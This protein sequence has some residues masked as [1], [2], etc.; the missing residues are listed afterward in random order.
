M[1]QYVKGKFKSKGKT[2]NQR[3]Q[4]LRDAKAIEK[5]GAF[6][7]VVEAI[8][9]DLSKK[10]SNEVKIP[11]IG[12]GSSVNCDGQILVTDDIL[13]LTKSKIKF[14]KKYVNLK[15]YIR[16]AAKK[17]RSEVLLKKYPSKKYSY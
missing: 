4:I 6:G 9:S 14:V 16:E 5:A 12:I 2:A 8:V 1:P 10:I 3:N 7:I 11:T 15:K 13:G 17:F